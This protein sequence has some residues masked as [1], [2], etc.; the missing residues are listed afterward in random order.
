MLAEE[1]VA[2][3]IAGDSRQLLFLFLD[4]G[5]LNLFFTSDRFLRHRRI[6]QDIGEN[7]SA[8]FQVG[9]GEVERNAERVVA[10]SSFSSRA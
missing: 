8:Q 5:E 10:R 7:I 6:Q 9:L 3:N 2:Q 4:P 1:R